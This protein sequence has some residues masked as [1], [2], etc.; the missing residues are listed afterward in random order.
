MAARAPVPVVVAPPR[1]CTDN[2]AMVA[3]CGFFRWQAGDRAGLDLD[4]YPNLALA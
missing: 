1:L 4:I 2:G 3:A